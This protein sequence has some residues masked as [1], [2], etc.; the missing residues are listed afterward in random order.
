VV[1][2]A[3]LAYIERPHARDFATPTWTKYL[4]CERR[5][6]SVRHGDE[7]LPGVAVVAASGHSAGSVAVAVQQGDGVALI[8]GDALPDAELARR[9]QTRL[10]FW[11]LAEARA[12]AA[13]LADLADVA[14]PGHDRPFRVADGQTEYLSGFSYHYRGGSR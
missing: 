11:D 6:R 10:V 12:S 4:F 5:V 1:S 13:R 8:T 2:A 7:I 3:K 9:R 14:Y